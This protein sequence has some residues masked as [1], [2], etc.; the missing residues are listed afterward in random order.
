VP[1]QILPGLDRVPLESVKQLSPTVPG[2]LILAVP[3]GLRPGTH[4]IAVR[5]SSR[6]KPPALTRRT[7]T[8]R[9]P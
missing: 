6:Y 1:T 4:T 3:G 9:L 8:P 7:F 2:S 5:I